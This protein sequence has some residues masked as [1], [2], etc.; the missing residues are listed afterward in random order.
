[1]KATANDSV[2]FQT[3]PCNSRETQ[4]PHKTTLFVFIDHALSMF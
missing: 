3:P 1:M 4:L 2:G